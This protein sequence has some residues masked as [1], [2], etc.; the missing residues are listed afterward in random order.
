MAVVKKLSDS[1][2]IC[3][4][5]DKYMEKNKAE[6]IAIF[7]TLGMTNEVPDKKQNMDASLSFHHHAY[8]HSLLKSIKT[9]VSPINKNNNWIR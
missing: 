9:I 6:A 1:Q 2:V 4:T 3:K 5:S 7:M 8:S